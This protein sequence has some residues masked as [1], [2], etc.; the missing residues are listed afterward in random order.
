MYL[1]NFNSPGRDNY[2]LKLK[3]ARQQ[4]SKFEYGMGFYVC[5]PA[6]YQQ[7]VHTYIRT[8]ICTYNG[9]MDDLHFVGEDHV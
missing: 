6:F 8:N 9:T 5:T 1:F 2:T 3:L 4:L 7:Y